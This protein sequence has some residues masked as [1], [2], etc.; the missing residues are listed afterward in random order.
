MLNSQGTDFI[1]IRT[2][3]SES[4]Y[5]TVNDAISEINVICQLLTLF[6][7][8]CGNYCYFLVNNVNNRMIWE[9]MILF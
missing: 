1:S 3:Y 2:R 4:I 9:M 8:E 7:Y 6:T 5:V